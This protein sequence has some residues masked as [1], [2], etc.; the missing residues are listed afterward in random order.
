MLSANF[1]FAYEIGAEKLQAH[2]AY[3]GRHA[4]HDEYRRGNQ[5]VATFLL[6]T[7]QATQ[8]LVGNIF[9]QPLFA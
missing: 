5:A 6:H 9:T 1:V 7:R 8:E 3:V 2:G 4:M